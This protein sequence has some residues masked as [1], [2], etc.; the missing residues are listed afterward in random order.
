MTEEWADDGDPCDPQLLGCDS[1]CSFREPIDPHPSTVNFP[2][3]RPALAR[4]RPDRRHG[5]PFFSDFSDAAGLSEPHLPA[6]DH[7]RALRRA[8]LERAAR[9]PGER[10]AVELAVG[11]ER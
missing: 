3:S 5:L 2:P 9:A 4:A 8:F 7:A 10:G 11:G 1:S 6:V